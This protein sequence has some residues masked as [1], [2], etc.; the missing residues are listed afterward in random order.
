MVVKFRNEILEEAKFLSDRGIKLREKISKTHST[1]GHAHSFL[2]SSLDSY[3]KLVPA[4]D[5]DGLA[6]V[7]DKDVDTCKT[8][9][10]RSAE[11]L[12]LV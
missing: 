6:T 4:V 8:I 11:S 12:A 5:F 9:S 3:L 1:A 7:L 10:A 2:K